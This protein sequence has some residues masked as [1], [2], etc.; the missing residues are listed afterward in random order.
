[1]VEYYHGPGVYVCI[2]TLKLEN[3]ISRIVFQRPRRRGTNDP[4][5]GATALVV[6]RGSEGGE[7][8]VTNSRLLSPQVLRGQ[9]T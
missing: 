3:Q 8:S 9:Q 6:G 1:M 7:T 4:P 5:P 2:T